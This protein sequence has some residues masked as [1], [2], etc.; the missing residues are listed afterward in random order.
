MPLLTQHIAE[1]EKAYPEA[2]KLARMF[3]DLYEEYAPQFGYITNPETRTFDP[4]SNN[5]RLMA[6]VCHEV[7]TSS[8]T[9]YSE[10][11]MVEI[12][13]LPKYTGGSSVEPKDIRVKLS[14]IQALLK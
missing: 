8:L 7:V 14:D 6:K 11:L 1:V 4:A 13:G 9:Q 5:G 10:K 2:Y 12:E 3:H